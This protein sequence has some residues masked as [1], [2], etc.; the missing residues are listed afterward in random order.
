[1]TVVA[2]KARIKLFE[3]MTPATQEVA[4]EFDGKIQT[5]SVGVIMNAYKMGARVAAIVEN[6]AEYGDN[7]VN[8]LAGYLNIPG[9]E[10][11][12]Y[13]YMNIAKAV[14]KDF[15]KAKS[16][17]AMAN[18]QY[19]TLSHWV[20]LAK[21][22]DPKNRDSLLEKVYKKSLSARDL[23]VEIRAGVGGKTKN[24]RQ[25]GRK[26]KA[27]SSAAVGLQQVFALGNKYT[28]FTEIA[29]VSVFDALDELEPDKVTGVLV[30]RAEKALEITRDVAT[31]AADAAG[32]LEGNISRLK[33]VLAAAEKKADAGED[34]E[35]EEKPAKK[36]GK[37]EAPAGKG[38]KTKKK[39]KKKAKKPVAAE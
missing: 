16:S 18:G 20:Q 2:D 10:T 32:R 31:K 29:D 33:D 21:L 7:A 26:P 34:A 28:R 24:A 30:E 8:L 27:P 13:M 25:G 14:D 17:I 23:E 19:L 4:R 22:E 11:V 35:P 38:D 6:E 15:I 37:A 9:G 39:K 12:L 3:K 1:M 5:T 36:K